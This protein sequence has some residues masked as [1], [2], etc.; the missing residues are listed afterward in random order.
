M[1]TAETLGHRTRRYGVALTVGCAVVVWIIARARS[2]SPLFPVS[3]EALLEIYTLQAL[4]GRLLVGP[5]S[6]FMWHH[7]GPIYFYLL[8]PFYVATDHLTSGLNAG[9]LTINLT[10]LLVAGWAFARHRAYGLALAFAT[11]G[12]A[13]VFRVG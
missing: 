12:I 11:F 6:R 5:Y 9:A 1:T 8:A 2:L 7:P 3:D 13:Y 4:A 10:A